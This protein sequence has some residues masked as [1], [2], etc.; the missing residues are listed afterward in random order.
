M[1][2]AQQ[3]ILAGAVLVAIATIL[4]PIKY[5]FKAIWKWMKSMS[6]TISFIKNLEGSLSV[7]NEK[8]DKV[9]EEFSPNGGSSLRD[10]TN[11]IEEQL[12][13]YDSRNKAM[14][15]QSDE[16]IFETDAAGLCVWCNRTYLEITNTTP[17]EVYGTGWVNNI[18]PEDSEEVF[19]KW[20]ESVEHEREF[21]LKYRFINKDDESIPVH[22]HSYPLRNNY[23]DIVGYLGIVKIIK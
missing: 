5:V 1:D 4:K 16:A 15:A 21:D 3:I 8:L 11:R 23:Q 2:L 14:V 13:L 10:A 18:H 22:V 9:T 6:N 17:E 19:E 20:N 7:I 12:A